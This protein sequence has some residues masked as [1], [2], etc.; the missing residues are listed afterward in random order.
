MRLP[1][2][3]LSLGLLG[4]FAGSAAVSHAEPSAQEKAQATS[5]FDQA[6]GEYKAQRYKEALPLFEGSQQLSPSVG[7]LLYIGECHR[8]LGRLASAWGAFREAARLALKLGDRREQIATEKAGELEK[9]L[10]FLAIEVPADR[11]PEGLEIKQDGRVV[12]PSLWGP[13]VPIDSGPHTLEFSAPGHEPATVEIQI[14]GDGTKT[15]ERAPALRPSRGT[16]PPPVP[17]AGP[18]PAHDPQGR[19]LLSLQVLPEVP[20]DNTEIKIDESARVTSEWGKLVELPPGV[21]TIQVA[22]RCREPLS[23][24]IELH[25]GY[26][27]SVVVP[28]PPPKLPAPAGCPGAASASKDASRSTLRAVGFVAAGLGAAVGA[29][30]GLVAWRA[31]T[32]AT[33]AK[34]RGEE[35]EHLRG[36]YRTGLVLLGIGGAVAIAGVVLVLTHPSTP[37]SSALRLAPVI[38]HREG[39]L[40]LSG[41]W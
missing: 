35:F 7:A 12:P 6:M 2:F 28:L 38:G 30:G 17:A 29:G 9:K 3:S 22:V 21:H 19:T 11:R 10:S 39:G 5:L 1:V 32:D 25:K 24:R 34:N 23:H 14:S 8:Q 40:W 36:P 18:E 27:H 41:R 20:R 37:S 33:D 16:A 13:S 15:T 31:A 4:A 26:L